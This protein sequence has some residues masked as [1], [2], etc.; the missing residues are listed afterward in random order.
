MNNAAPKK[1][2]QRLFRQFHQFTKQLG[3]KQENATAELL[4]IHLDNYCSSVLRQK[5]KKELEFKPLVRKTPRP[6]DQPVKQN[7]VRK[8][9][10]GK[11]HQ[12]FQ[13]LCPG[14]PERK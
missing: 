5:Q 4:L 1:E 8:P 7:I 3:N 11:T 6:R 12:E 10:D 2:L 13:Q 9:W 14:L